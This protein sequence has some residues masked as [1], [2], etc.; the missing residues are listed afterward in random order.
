M[1]PGAITQTRTRVN[2][3]FI[4]KL[5]CERE[6]GKRLAVLENSGGKSSIETQGWGM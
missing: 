4:V 2:E 6:M 5:I 1:D 3:Q